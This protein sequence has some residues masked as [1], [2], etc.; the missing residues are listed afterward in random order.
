MRILAVYG[1]LAVSRRCRKLLF[2]SIVTTLTMLFLSRQR[3]R[4]ITSTFFD[5]LLLQWNFSFDT[6][7]LYVLGYRTKLSNIRNNTNFFR[8]KD[9]KKK[10]SFFF[11]LL[12]WVQ[13]VSPFL[14]L[15]HYYLIYSLSYLLYW[16]LSMPR[17]EC[18]YI[19]RK[20]VMEINYKNL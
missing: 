2:L 14:L 7:V 15:F 3:F 16:K 8:Q 5:F 4:L 9:E 12:H 18:K 13:T 19:K 6:I 20:K 17:I 11:I 1:M 10:K